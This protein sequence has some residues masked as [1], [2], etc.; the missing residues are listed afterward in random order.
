MPTQRRLSRVSRVNSDKT[1]PTLGDLK[2]LTRIDEDLKYRKE[3][4]VDQ[5][6]DPMLL[7]L[8][9]ESHRRRDPEEDAPVVL[10]S[11]GDYQVVPPPIFYHD[12]NTPRA[13]TEPLTGTNIKFHNRAIVALKDIVYWQYA[14]IGRGTCAIRGETKDALTGKDLIVKISWPPQWRRNEANFLQAALE[15]ALKQI[16]EPI[17]GHIPQVL[18]HRGSYSKA[19]GPRRKWVFE[20]DDHRVLRVIVIHSYFPMSKLHTSS[21]VTQVMIDVVKRKDFSPILSWPSII[22][23]R[24]ISMNNILSSCGKDSPVIGIPIDFD[25]AVFITV[26]VQDISLHLDRRFRT[27]TLPLMAINLM[28]Q[29]R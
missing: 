28:G 5:F 29:A 14:L 13:V 22:L 3:I 9:W 17:L 23:H 19:D 27:G 2:P 18:L 6:I 16:D 11:S 25:L 8:H 24:N 12:S 1:S 21:E 7:L 20:D 26:D 4:P 10:Q 15:Y